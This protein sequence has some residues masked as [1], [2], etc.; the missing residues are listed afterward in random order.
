MSS[1]LLVLFNLI[2]AAAVGALAAWAII[3]RDRRAGPHRESPT[4]RL[5]HDT[6]AES[7]A[8]TTNLEPSPP[9]PLPDT[10]ESQSKA[11]TGAEDT[12][13]VTELAD[14]RRVLSTL[15]R[16]QAETESRL[17]QATQPI[18]ESQRSELDLLRRQVQQ[19]L[20]GFKGELE[21]FEQLLNRDKRKRASGPLAKHATGKTKSSDDEQQLIGQLV[22]EVNGLHKEF[23]FV[24][25]ARM[26][27][28][29]GAQ[30]DIVL[31]DMR[32]SETHV[33][34]R[35]DAS[36]GFV[37]PLGAAHPVLLNGR[38]LVKPT[39]L[40]GGD[41]VSFSGNSR[42]TFTAT[43]VQEAERRAPARLLGRRKAKMGS[44]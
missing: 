15:V 23:P 29:R 14:M 31:Q 10:A 27:L 33:A 36:K 43:A 18:G 37:E 42:L 32:L 12:A 38:R 20:A 35:S 13:L 4:D 30:N 39:L 44:L 16:Q 25:H 41:V 22:L 9:S 11:I 3:R 17:A 19:Q 21:R 24:A 1:Y 26:T 5:E 40:K 34:F 28:G 7:R 8:E 6:R 2:A